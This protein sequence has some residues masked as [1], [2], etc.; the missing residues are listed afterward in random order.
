[1]LMVRDINLESER[2]YTETNKYGGKVIRKL[3][4]SLPLALDPFHIQTVNTFPILQNPEVNCCFNICTPHAASCIQ[5]TTSYHISLRPILIS[6]TH[7]QLSQVI[8]SISSVLNNKTL[9]KMRRFALSIKR[10]GELRRKGN[11]KLER[12]RQARNFIYLF[13]FIILLF[14]QHSL[15]IVK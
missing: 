13:P 2:N 9:Q 11:K 6:P 3:K 10:N 15:L 8:L 5:F 12:K 14:I 7:A 4:K 1:M